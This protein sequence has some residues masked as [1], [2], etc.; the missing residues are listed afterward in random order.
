M[1]CQQDGFALLHQQLQA[2]PHQVAGLRI[3]PGGRLVQQQQLRVVHQRAR[4]REPAAHAA[5]KLARLGI[6][7]MGKGCE[8]QQLGHAGLN[9][10]ICHAEIAAINEQV[11]GTGEIRVQRVELADHT[12]ARLDGQRV[13]RHVQTAFGLS[14]RQ[15]G[16]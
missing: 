5:R 11:F 6:R 9:G 14:I 15:K 3:Q 12:Q 2:F 7:F 16:D 10:G 4:Q 1:R 13:L 8:L